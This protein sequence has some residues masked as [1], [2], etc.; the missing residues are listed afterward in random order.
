[1]LRHDIVRFG[2]AAA[3]VDRLVELASSVQGPLAAARADHTAGVVAVDP[4]RLQAAVAGFEQIGSPLLAAE[5]ALDLADAAAATGD[6]AG[7][8]VARDRAKRLLAQLDPTGRH[9]STQPDGLNRPSSAP[10]SMASAI[11]AYMRR[12]D[13][14]ASADQPSPTTSAIAAIR[15]SPK[16]V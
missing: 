16:K 8:E 3:V 5:A 14:S 10:S 9:A 1:M 6:D 2:G 11:S 13:A 15:A 7:A 4:P 12:H